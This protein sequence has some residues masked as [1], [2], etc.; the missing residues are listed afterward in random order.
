MTPNQQKVMTYLGSVTDASTQEITSATGVK[1]AD[2]RVCLTDLYV[3]ELI[4]KARA[5]TRQAYRY[6]LTYAG[7]RMAARMMRYQSCISGDARSDRIT[8]MTQPEYVPPSW[9]YLR[10]SGHVGIASRGMM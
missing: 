4:D 5:T 9:G 2:F 7:E 6:S 3:D 1:F 8:P 10:N